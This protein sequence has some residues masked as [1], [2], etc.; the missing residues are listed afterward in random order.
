MSQGRA[1]RTAHAGAVAFTSDDVLYCSMPLFHGNALLANLFPAMVSGASVALRGAGSRRRSSCPTSAATA[2]PTSTTSAGR[3]PTCSPSPSARRRRQPAE[4]VPRLRGVAARP[5]GVPAAVRVLRGRGLQLERGR[6]GH[7]A[8]LRHAA[9]GASAARARAWT[10]RSSTPTR[11]SSARA[12]ASATTGG[13]ST[14]EEAI[15]EIVGRERAV[16]VRGLLRQPGGHRRARPRRVVLDG[17]PRLPG[18]GRHLLLRRPHRRLAARRR[19][20]LRRRTRSSA[21]L[22]RFPGVASVGRLRRCPT[23]APATR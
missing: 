15:G 5:Q 14:P 22:G 11:A 13:C 23:R 17:R 10:S 18:R 20:E 8:L 9:R 3:C 21:I 19:R 12:P 1:A 16:V 2:A 6:G 4:V 7:H